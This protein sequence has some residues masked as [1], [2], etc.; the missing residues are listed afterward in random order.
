MYVTPAGGIG[1]LTLAKSG[2]L[3]LYNKLIRKFN[4]RKKF[5]FEFFKLELEHDFSCS[6][7]VFFNSIQFIY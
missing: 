3:N 1:N 4:I 2:M 6:L 5:M 7:A